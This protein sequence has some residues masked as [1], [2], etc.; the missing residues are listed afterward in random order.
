MGCFEGELG[1][2]DFQEVRSTM[3]DT[4]VA[5]K[6]LCM[7]YGSAIKA[8]HTLD[9]IRNQTLVPGNGVNTST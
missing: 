2:V 3:V 5:S 6:K 1:R 4:K 7:G 8:L 9:L